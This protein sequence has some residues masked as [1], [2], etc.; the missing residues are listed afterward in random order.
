MYNSLLTSNMKNLSVVDL[1]RARITNLFLL[2]GFAVMFFTLIYRIFNNPNLEM[3]LI[4]ICTSFGFLGAFFWLRRSHKLQETIYFSTFLII[5][6]MLFFTKLNHNVS[7]GLVWTYTVP[8]FV[9]PLNGYR[10]GLVLMGVYYA[11]IFG[12]IYIDYEDWL[13]N[14]WDRLSLVRYV[15]V[16]FSLVILSTFYNLIFE[17]F[18][19]EL[20]KHS[21]TDHL[22]NL[23]NRRKIDEILEHQ[24]S[25]I[26]RYSAQKKQFSI[27]IFDIDDFKRINDNFGHLIG[28]KVLKTIG[29]LLLK[30]LR[31]VDHAGRWGGEEFCIIMPHTNSQ[32]A[33][34]LVERIKKSINEYN[35]ELP[36][37]ITCSFG[38]A[39][40]DDFNLS[41]DTFIRYADT[42]MYRAKN[43]GKDRI[44]FG[45]K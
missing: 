24:I 20:Y 26:K 33:L 22:T 32:E 13:A 2:G 9:I 1:N 7:F 14:G 34:L 5:V 17:K 31:I 29:D 6:F 40:Y 28:D 30:N 3:I 21:T 27:C 39:T 38:V 35:F 15:I 36:W 42:A 18:R 37:K 43:E 23:L 44:Y 16:S 41:K 12:F 19:D 8:L 10:A 45:A 11:F 25:S 4:D